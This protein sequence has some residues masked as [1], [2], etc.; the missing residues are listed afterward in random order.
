MKNLFSYLPKKVL[1]AGAAVVAT[2]GIA[3]AATAWF[4]DRPTYTIEQPAD[5]VTF[6][7]ITN[8]P[9]EGDERA[10]FEVKDAA[11]TQPNGFSHTAQVSEGQEL[12]LRAYVHNNARDD[13]NGTNFNGPGVARNTKVRF[14]VPTATGQALR[15]NAYISADNATPREVADTIDLSG[16]SNFSLEYVPGSAVQYT[17]VV[18]SGIPLSDS[19]VTTGAPIGYTEANGVVPG[20]FQ[21]SSI[22]TIKVK[23]KTPKY[24]VQK[25]VRF[26]GQTSNDWKESVNAEPGQTVEW[27][28][29]FKNTGQTPLNSVKVVDEVPAGLTVVPGSV[30]LF[31]G[32]YPSGYTFPDSSIQSNGRQVNVDIGNYN[33]GINAFVLFKTKTPTTGQ[34]E[35][36]DKK[37]TNKAFATPE[38]YG[39]VVDTAEV[40]V[41]GKEDCK[42]PENPSYDCKMITVTQLGGRKI[43]VDVNT[44]ATNGATVKSYSYDF[45]DGK[46]ALVTDKNPVEY[47]YDKDGNFVVRV[48]VDFTV[49][50]QTKTV[51]NDVCAKPVNFTTPTTPITP[52]ST[53]TSGKL[54][55][56]GAGDVLG[57]FAAVTVAGAMAHRLFASRL[58]AR[59]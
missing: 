18:P 10:F 29:E 5:H 34:T 21:Y 53:P 39:A 51:S 20:C 59:S 57:I 55:E 41:K 28:I 54:V 36:G 49:N 17:N 43:R 12:L 30:R 4:P 25:S 27:R 35:C 40:N 58:S 22:V 56:T 46:P 8:N 16:N 11:N 31:N 14:H 13:L 3:T 7:S 2:I 44:T 33:P 42:P 26:E 47:T 19:I 50:G 1:F 52:A 15:A 23:V 45:G 48:S 38:G 37:F 32:N 6:N 24:S 9:N